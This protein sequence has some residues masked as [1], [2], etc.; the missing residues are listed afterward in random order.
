MKNIETFVSA[1]E[2]SLVAEILSEIE[3]K[4]ASSILFSLSEE[5]FLAVCREIE[6]RV[7]AEFLPYFNEEKLTAL[8]DALNYT[9]LGAV[10]SEIEPEQKVAVLKALPAELA[11]RVLSPED[12]GMLLHSLDLKYLKPLLAEMNAIDAARALEAVE[13]EDLPLLFRLLPKDLAAEAFV[14]IDSDKQETLIGKLNNL[15]I[16]RVM[17][18]LFLDDIADILEE[19][20]ANVVKK[21]LAGCDKE[22]RSRVNELLKYPKD[23]A[24]S[25]MTVEFVSLRPSMTVDQAFDKIRKTAIDKETIYTCY[26]VDEKNYLVGIVSA[27][28]LLLSQKDSLIEDVMET[29]FAYA[30]TTDDKEQAA[31]L[32]KEYSLLAIPVVDE[33][34]RLVGI[35]TV[36]DAIDV[37][38][39]EN[40]EDIEKMAAILP[41]EKPYLKTSVFSIWLKRIPWLLILMVS[42]TFTG[43]ILNTYE[44]KLAVISTVL[45][46]CVP[47]IMD[48][49]GNAGSQASVTVIRALALNELSTKD[50]F[51]VLWK[52]VRASVLLGLT[53]ALACF[54]K[55]MLIDNLLFGYADYTPFTCFV[56][57]L[58]LAC[59]VV[60][61]KLVGCTLPLLAKKAKLDPAVVASPFITTVVDAVSLIVYCSLAVALLGNV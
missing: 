4:E 59:T 23:S 12:V 51:R 46:A 30:V 19:M 26:V 21:L 34:K 18:D 7:L 41:S 9:E 15:E 33:E 52:E 36:D 45:F 25:I 61:A 47:M 44:S 16:H 11:V 42:A 1:K 31:N 35:V 32:L 2:Y 50:A 39:E 58:A 54:G 56:V 10:F 28:E 20:P 6:P 55:L 24:G 8:I 17:N 40:T 14:E 49:G 29:N 43:L 48:T 38:E 5:D 53:L 13:E 60:V 37:I 27:K 22:T 57:S 3:P